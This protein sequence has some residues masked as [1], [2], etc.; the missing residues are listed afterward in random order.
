VKRPLAYRA[1][2]LL[3]MNRAARAVFAPRLLVLCYHGACEEAP[4][5]QDPDGMRVPLRVFEE[6]L[7]FLVGHYRPVSLDQVR[8]HAH[9]DASLPPGAVLVTFDDGYR[10]VARHALPLLRARGVPCVL[11][12]VPGAVEAGGWLWT[13]DLEWRYVGTPGYAGFRRGLKALP[14]RDRRRWLDQHLRNGEPG[15]DCDYSLA[16]WDEMVA[17]LASGLVAIG[18]HGLSHQPLTTCDEPDLSE[19][20]GGAKQLI[21]ERLGV[22]VDAVAYPN[23]AWS[24]VVVAA[25]REAGYR[26]GFTTVPRHVRLATTP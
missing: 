1:A 14:V 26:L 3:G 16:G 25:A 13:S 6:Q 5:V 11:F 17:A 21:Q 9:A 8:A 20:L 4:D 2:S 7:D 23:G 22:E 19:E 24:P 18:A 15:P 10:N 12:P